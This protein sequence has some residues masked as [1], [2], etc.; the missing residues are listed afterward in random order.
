MNAAMK[1]HRQG[2]TLVELMIV[3]SIV[4]LLAAIALPSYRNHVLRTNRTVAKAALVDLVSRQ[5]SYYVDR[6][7]YA[8]ATTDV[9]LQQYL[10][11]DTST[12]A[13][14]TSESLYRLSIAALG[15]STCPASGSAT[16]SGYTL[17]ATP[18][19]SQTG[20]IGCGT[21]CLT[22]T[23]IKLSSAGNAASCWSR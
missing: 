6:K 19:G 9:G 18:V 23:G 15:T 12:T 13:S 16:P 20:D 5:E 17:M 2:F 4:G 7:I 3:V 11:R 21:L 22:S 1:H 14:Q 10:S 8:I